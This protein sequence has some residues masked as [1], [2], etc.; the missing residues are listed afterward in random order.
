MGLQS[1]SS[2]GTGWST[3]K[4]GLVAAYTATSAPFAGVLPIQGATRFVIQPKYDGSDLKMVVL[5]K[6]G[7]QLV[8]MMPLLC[9]YLSCSSLVCRML[10]NL[11]AAYWVNHQSDPEDTVLL[12]M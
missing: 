9:W 2:K 3:V 8:A 12:F 4:V 6:P 10:H 11:L 5:T 1:C 7:L